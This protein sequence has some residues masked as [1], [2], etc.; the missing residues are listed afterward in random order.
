MRFL[1][2][3]FGILLLLV[4]AVVVGGY[5]FLKNFD[6]NKYKSLAEEI[7]YNQT[8]R[9]LVIAGDASL[10]ISLVPTLVIND[11][12]FA[13]PEWAKNPQMAE[14]G[15]LEL[16]FSLLPLL[17]KQI[18]VDKAVVSDAEIYLETTADGKNS[19]TFTPA[20]TEEKTPAADKRAAAGGW[21]IAAAYAGETTAAPAFLQTLNDI[22]ARE[23]AVYE[24]EVN[25]LAAGAEP[26]RLQITGL[27]FS[28][29]GI[30][31][32]MNLDWDLLFN[33]TEISGK[34][35]TGSL[36]DLFAAGKPWPADVEV[37]A[38]NVRAEAKAEL[39]DL[40]ASPRAEFSINVHNPAGNFNAPETTLIADG[41]ADM[42]KVE[43]NISSLDVVNNVI[44]GTVTA[45][46][47]G[48]KPYVAA[49]LN[50]RQI[51]LRSF[52]TAGST[53]FVLPALISSA[54][55][56]ELVPDIAVPYDLLQTADADVDVAVGR[57][58]VNDAFAADNVS[59]KAKLNNG[60]LNINP[61]QMQFGQGTVKMT[62]GVDGAARSVVLGIN[63]EDLLLQDLHR[64]FKVEGQND[65]GVL[66]GGKSE[67]YANLRASG[68][69]LRALTDSLSGELI[70]LAEETD[71]Q[72][73]ALSF[74]SSNFARQLLDVLKIDTT[75]AEKAELKCAVVRADVK[76]GVINFP[77]G[78]AIDSDKLSIV[79]GGTV[80]LQN[81]R[82][83]LSLNAYRSGLAD[84]SVMQA[85]SNLVEIGGT[86]PSPKIA[87][88]KKGTVKTIAGLV[89]GPAY[90]GADMLFDRDPAP[91]H[92]ALLNTRYADRFP[93]ASAARGAA[94]NT[95]QGASDAVSAGV[96]AA[97]DAAKAIGQGAGDAAKAIGNNADR[98]AKAIG[99]GARQLIK[100][101][102]K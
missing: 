54:A 36:A 24:S 25:Y 88:D 1:K 62:A 37:S 78:I 7:A 35:T 13:N 10:G 99:Q 8:G 71:I 74:L 2:W 100:N 69:T 66:A 43:L 31:A 75:R 40:T 91:C 77:K 65:F 9:K 41:R 55:A 57:L 92:T 60:V 48:K 22:V 27:A 50:S 97:S 38:F 82:L 83:Q 70:V 63:T 79:S 86:L 21:L 58:V 42:R 32:P 87:L 28:A 29:E 98:A 72:S 33:G 51:D 56:S 84:I 52:D 34:G 101:L 20:A 6:L 23:V 4:V 73:G 30:N 85:L 89:A 67:V 14:I 26:V 90:A 94:H 5:V 102:L 68:K 47:A 53:A 95:Y 15:T 12:S 64:E 11:I 76:N 18:V 93:A 45:D 46:I 16:K 44:T 80:N 59:L 39:Y 49:D 17:K 61:L 81:D 96:N 3:L 19:W